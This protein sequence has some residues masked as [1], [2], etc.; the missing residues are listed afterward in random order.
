MTAEITQIA[1]NKFATRHTAA[2]PF[3]YHIEGMEA[4]VS[5]TREAALDAANVSPGY[6]EGVVTVRVPAAGFLSGVVT[7]KEGD[8]ISGTF[9]ARRKGEKPRKQVLGAGEKMAAA[10][11]DIVLYAST[12]LAE[13]G[14]NDL[15][16]EAGNWEI[17]SVNASP[18]EGDIPMDPATLMANHFRLDGGTDTKMS[19]E[20]FEKALH[21]AV[22]FWQDKAMCAG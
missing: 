1:T 7:L 20:E 12:V 6:R 9:K 21:D 8:A 14:D 2:S 5:L 18:V 15:A 19:A 10:Q 17:I 22:I 16:A 4:V 3:S 11:V 13:D